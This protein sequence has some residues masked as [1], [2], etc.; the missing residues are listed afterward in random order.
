MGISQNIKQILS[1]CRHQAMESLDDD[2]VPEAVRRLVA[3]AEIDTGC[4]IFA[5][6]QGTFVD[7]VPEDGRSID[8]A[9]YEWHMRAMSGNLRPGEPKRVKRER[10]CWNLIVDGSADK[11]NPI[12][13][14][15]WFKQND[16]EAAAANPKCCQII[17]F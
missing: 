11:G 16:V 15:A 14:E 13:L 3:V 9:K 5:I 10:G 12:S 4:K 1:D 8:G 2:N 7:Y 17:V 6:K